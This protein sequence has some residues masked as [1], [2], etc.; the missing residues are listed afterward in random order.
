MTSNYNEIFIE[1]SPTNRSKHIEMLEMKF[2]VG[3]KIIPMHISSSLRHSASFGGFSKFVDCT[4]VDFNYYLGAWIKIVVDYSE[5][6]SEDA[7]E[8]RYKKC[9]EFNKYYNPITGELGIEPFNTEST[10]YNF[11]FE[12]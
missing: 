7:Y 3:T 1:I 10:S 4:I 9:L 2:V 12:Y 11:R 5:W 6:R 8:E